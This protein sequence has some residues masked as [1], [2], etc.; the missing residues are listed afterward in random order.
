[1][2][3]NF[4]AILAEI[5][6]VPLER[7]EVKLSTKVIAIKTKAGPA[8]GSTIVELTTHG[9]ETLQFDAAVVTTPLGWLKLNKSV[10][11]PRLEKDLVQAI[12]DISVGHLEK[13]YITFPN[14]FW[15]HEPVTNREGEPKHLD[16]A[17]WLAPG[18]ARDTNPFGWPI[19]A[20]NLA[21]VGANSHPTLLLYTFGDL[22]KHI[23]S[24]VH[25]TPDKDEQYDALDEF[26]RPYYS[27][28]PH[29]NPQ[30]PD[31]KPKGYLAST[32][33]YDEMAGYGSYSNMQVGINGADRHV[34]R[35]QDGMPDRGL[36]FA[37]EHVSPIE[38]RGTMGGAWFSGELAAKKIADKYG[39]LQ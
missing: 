6:K 17:I 32:W 29:Y 25:H 27:L 37:G 13:V 10:F 24:I 33:R 14:A 18:Y 19:E 4:S 8:T 11:E 21:A 26:F 15:K 35:L 2:P 23:C 20:Y 38:E 7:A 30:D 22:S 9:G 5:A 34:Q 12:D 3:N 28:L 1:V 39:V 16:H 31:C 36:F